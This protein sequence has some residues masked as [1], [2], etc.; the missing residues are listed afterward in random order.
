M[1]RVLAVRR[2]DAFLEIGPGRG[3]LTRPLAARCAHVWAVEIDPGLAGP[4]ATEVP[5]NVSVVTGDALTIDFAALGLPEPSRV[6]GNLPY[7]VASQ[8]LVRLLAVSAEGRHVRDATLMLQ[9]EVADRVTAEP[10]GPD[11]GPLAVATRLAAVPTRV[12][13]LPPGA[14]RP[15]PKVQSAVVSLTFRPPPVRVKDRALFDAL[16]RRIFTQRR[17]TA[18]NALRAFA[19]RHSDRSV[20][21]IFARAGIDGS[22]RPGQLELAELAEL[23]AVLASSGR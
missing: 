7:N 9:R 23:S 6:V 11:W 3:A 18:A 20:A 4:L 12:M 1:I 5:A 19:A 17:K 10:G 16:V 22:R 2:T 8:I 21:E 13:T 15:M 14:F